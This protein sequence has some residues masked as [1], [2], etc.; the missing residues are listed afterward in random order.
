MPSNVVQGTVD[1]NDTVSDGLLAGFNLHFEDAGASRHRFTAMWYARKKDDGKAEKPPPN[2]YVEDDAGTAGVDESDDQDMVVGYNDSA[3]VKT[4]DDD[5]D[6]IYGDIGKVSID[7]DDDSDNFMEN[8]DSRECSADDGGSAATG[9]DGKDKNSTLCDA[10]GAEI[11]ASVSFPLG[12]GYGCDPVEVAY[13][14]TCDWSSRGNRTNTVDGGGAGIVLDDP[15]TD[16]EG[17]IG[18]FVKCEV[19]KS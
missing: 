12:L 10:D 5:F 15:A 14:L 9:K 7:G 16:D 11:E 8:D 2:L 6:P 4:I 13:T 18:D 17:N 3:W 19:E 1:A